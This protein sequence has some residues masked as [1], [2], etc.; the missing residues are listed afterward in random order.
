VN[1]KETEG[2]FE[3]GRGF[4]ELLSASRSSKAKCVEMMKARS[5]INIKQSAVTSGQ[6]SVSNSTHGIVQQQIKRRKQNKAW[7]NIRL[8]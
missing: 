2:Q 6:V 7:P 4:D 3:R 5:C 8:V 1:V